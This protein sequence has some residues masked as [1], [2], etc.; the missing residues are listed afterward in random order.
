[1]KISIIGAG[2]VGSATACALLQSLNAD[3]IILIDILKNLAEGEALDLNYAAVGLGKK[4]RFLGGDD[5][6]LAKDSDFVVITAGKA[7]KPGETRED[8]F[9]FNSKIVEDIC[10]KLQE[11]C[12]DATI[13][14]I[15]NPAS[16]ITEIVRKYFS[17]VIGME[18]QLDTSRAKYFIAGETGKPIK[19]IKSYVQGGHGEDMYIEFK[20]KLT[21]EQKKR[22]TE[23]VKNAGPEIIALKGATC[24]GIAAHTLEIIRNCLRNK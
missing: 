8:L 11:I 17:K 15:T 20:E 23:Q 16:Q 22:I 2:R 10:R 7:R 1:M 24:W 18:N 6:N 14:V 21:D 12:R 4:T 5:Y 9:A 3:D 13:L 19:S